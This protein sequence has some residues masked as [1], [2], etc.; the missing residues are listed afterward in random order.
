M[1]LLLCMLGR[2]IQVFQKDSLSIRDDVRG[3]EF[4]VADILLVL[5]QPIQK[6]E[7]DQ[8]GQ[9][10]SI[11]AKKSKMLKNQIIVSLCINSI[12]IFPY[13]LLFKVAAVSSWQ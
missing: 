4:L 11:L 10:E 8:N 5:N 2:K 1:V 6:V 13:S 12:L 3:E 9:V 7:F